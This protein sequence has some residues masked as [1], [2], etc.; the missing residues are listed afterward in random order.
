MSIDRRCFRFRSPVYNT[1]RSAVRSLHF[2]AEAAGV[3]GARECFH[4]SNCD[5]RRRRPPNE[6]S[7]L[8]T[9]NVDDDDGHRSPYVLRRFFVVCGQPATR[10]RS[11]ASEVGSRIDCSRGVNFEATR[12]IE[13]LRRGRLSGKGSVY[14][15][16]RPFYEIT[17]LTIIF[18]TSNLQQS[19]NSKVLLWKINIECSF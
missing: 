6:S 2:D 9:C 11:L 5:V 13:G 17:T 10:H 15:L 3:V 12:L 16:R 14:G 7:I 1:V 8:T 4:R 19:S 18:I